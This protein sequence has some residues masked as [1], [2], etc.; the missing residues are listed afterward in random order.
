MTTATTK[1]S[2]QTYSLMARWSNLLWTVTRLAVIHRG[3]QLVS[4]GTW[5]QVKYNTLS[6]LKILSCFEMNVF[7]N[8]YTRTMHNHPDY[9]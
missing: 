4:H 2:Q 5:Y 1:I 7:S 6:Y 9:C 3:S 8:L